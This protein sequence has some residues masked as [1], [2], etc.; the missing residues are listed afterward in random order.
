MMN[1]TGKN[2]LNKSPGNGEVYFLFL[3]WRLSLALCIDRCIQ[4]YGEEVLSSTINDAHSQKSVCTTLWNEWSITEG[5][6]WRL[7]GGV[8]LG[9]V[10]P[11]VTV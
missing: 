8:L 2:Y 11:R 1:H 5:Y 3:K 9:A 7:R 10:P 4:A 6:F